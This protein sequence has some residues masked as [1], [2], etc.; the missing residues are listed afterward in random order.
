MTAKKTEPRFSCC[1]CNRRHNAVVDGAI[2]AGWRIRQSD[3]VWLCPEHAGTR[4]LTLRRAVDTALVFWENSRVDESEQSQ[5]DLAAAM[6][7]LREVAVADRI[8][9]SQTT[10]R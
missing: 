1:Y 4:H 8:F 7:A 3:Q 10:G 9:D 2:A 6:S 5:A